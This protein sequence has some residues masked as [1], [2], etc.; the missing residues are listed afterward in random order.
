MTD[1][2]TM[3]AAVV[4]EPHLDTPRTVLADWLD[5]HD[6]PERAA[7]VRLD[8]PR[9][10]AERRLR[11]DVLAER[12]EPVTAVAARLE[13]EGVAGLAEFARRQLAV[14]AYAGRHT[15]GYQAQIDWV[16]AALL[17]DWRRW[18][19]PAVTTLTRKADREAYNQDYFS[20]AIRFPTRRRPPPRA[21][22]FR[23]P[24]MT[25]LFAWGLP[26]WVRCDRED[27]A[28]AGL[29]LVRRF[30]WVVY[31]PVPG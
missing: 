29:D 19:P 11:A 3:I 22:A 26:E 14:D 12:E 5:D 15:A 4:A 20:P 27:W 7:A 16:Y 24:A 28:R 31:D 6:Q 18:L 25:V 9:R 21:F 13:A 23:Q 10:N 2:T 1:E 17:A 30:P 8:W